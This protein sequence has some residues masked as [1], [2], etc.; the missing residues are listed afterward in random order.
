[1]GVVHNWL[2]PEDQE[3]DWYLANGSFGKLVTKMPEVPKRYPSKL[4]NNRSTL[5]MPTLHLVH[6]LTHWT[7]KEST[8][9]TGKSP[10][11]SGK[12]VSWPLQAPFKNFPLQAQLPS[13]NSWWGLR[14]VLAVVAAVVPDPRFGLGVSWTLSLLLAAGFGCGQL[15]KNRTTFL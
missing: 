7:I 12:S 8:H 2:F 15:R 13:K 3:E 5:D 10:R 4:H 11:S 14:V 1:M 9:R 6:V